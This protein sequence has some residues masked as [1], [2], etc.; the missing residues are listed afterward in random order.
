MLWKL[1]CGKEAGKNGIKTV[2]YS[3]ASRQSVCGVT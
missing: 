3:L 1:Y 2:G